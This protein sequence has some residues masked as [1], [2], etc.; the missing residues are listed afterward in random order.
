MRCFQLSQSIDQKYSLNISPGSYIISVF[1]IDRW[2]KTKKNGAFS[3]FIISISNS[4]RTI[5]QMTSISGKYNERIDMSYENNE[6]NF[7]YRPIPQHASNNLVCKY[8][9]NIIN[10]S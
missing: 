7:F 1:E 6:L 8:R 9:I 10:L 3:T 4:K 2:Y 5:N